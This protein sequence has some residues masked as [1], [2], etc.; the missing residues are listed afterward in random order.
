MEKKIGFIGLG[1]MG[2]SMAG[3]LMDAGH[4]LYVYSRTKAKCGDIIEK[5]AHWCD[6][7]KAV[8]ENTDI[9]FTIVGFP[10]DVEE[11]YL[12]KNGLIEGT[13][14]GMIFCDMTTTKPSLDIQ[15]GKELEKKGASMCDAP[16]SGG[17]SG[18]RNATLSIM[19]GADKATFNALLPYFN[20]MGKSITHMG[21]LGAG[22]HTKM[23]NQ[24]VIAGTMCGVSEALVYGAR[25]GL[26]TEKMV[27][28]ISKGAA[29]CWTLDNLA[30]RV[31]RDDL[32]PGFMVDHF[33]KD[34]GIALEEAEKME[35][36]LPSLA[37]TKQ[38]YLSLKANGMGRNGTQA[39]V[40]AIE[41][42]SGM[43]EK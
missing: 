19:A 25:A 41:Q 13:R 15:I 16:V 26:D 20:I 28:T 12:G 30:P 24:I 14:E 27:Q 31:L 33:I 9:V 32:A 37:L 4:E 23:A 6:T 18:A 21:E 7:P 35:L 40:K 11:V 10:K 36:V 17:D 34:M 2:K 8:A 38:L 29:G 3:H 43:E 22:Q 5:G 39:L 1:V 42:L